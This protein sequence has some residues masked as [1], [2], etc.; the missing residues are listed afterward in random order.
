MGHS[1]LLG[2]L[3]VSVGFSCVFGELW[4]FVSF[5]SFH[6]DHSASFLVY[7]FLFVFADLHVF[8]VLLV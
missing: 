7:F 1:V 8:C 4:L 2:G 6:G 5:T 3:C